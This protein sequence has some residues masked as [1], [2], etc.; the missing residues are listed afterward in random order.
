MSLFAPSPFKEV[1]PL[2]HT[3]DICLDEFRY[4]TKISF[5]PDGNRISFLKYHIVFSNLPLLF[6]YVYF[7]RYL[8]SFLLTTLADFWRYHFRT[9]TT[10]RY[11]AV[12]NQT[13]CCLVRNTISHTVDRDKKKHELTEGQNCD[14]ENIV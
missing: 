3:I 14:V 13:Q 10:I 9:E 11:I 1:S 4:R 6:L 7:C 2:K 8:L 12:D 5:S